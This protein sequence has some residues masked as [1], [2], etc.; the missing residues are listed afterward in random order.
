MSQHFLLSAKVHTLSVRRVFEMNEKQAFKVFKKVRWG[1]G[2]EV[3]C[4]MRSVVN[5]Y[6]FIAIRKQWR[7]KD[8]SHTFSVT[9]GTI[10]AFYKL[11]LKMYL[12]AIAIYTNAV[13]DFVRLLG[14]SF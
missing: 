10:F 5:D 9:S 4:P 3:I 14:A 13:K 1:D 7:C 11:S 2:K 12:A 8:C 6:Y